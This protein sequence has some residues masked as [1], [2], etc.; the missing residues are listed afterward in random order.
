MDEV[1]IQNE[2]VVAGSVD[3]SHRHKPIGTKDTGSIPL[4]LHNN[5]N[6]I[7]AVDVMMGRQMPLC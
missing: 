3:K 2:A 4:R 6:E 1:T 7:V 5:M